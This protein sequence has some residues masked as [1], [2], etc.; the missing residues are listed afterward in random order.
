MEVQLFSRLREQ[1]EAEIDNFDVIIL[2]DHDI[3]QLDVTVRNLFT[4]KVLDAHDDPSKDFFGLLLR[5]A[6]LG[7]GLQVLVERRLTDI[8]H[9]EHNLLPGVDCCIELYYIRMV[10]LS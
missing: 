8:L 5:D 1:T 7:F 6:L 2:I 4:M 3:V 9:H 10:V